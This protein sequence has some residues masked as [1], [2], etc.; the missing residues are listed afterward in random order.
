MA[1]ASLSASAALAR[2]LWSC[3]GTLTSFTSTLS[4]TTPQG[5]VARSSSALIS[6]AM[7]LE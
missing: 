6:A 5:C 3:S 2:D 4:T 7:A 1:L